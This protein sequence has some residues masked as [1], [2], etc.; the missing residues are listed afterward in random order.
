MAGGEMVPVDIYFVA[1][2]AVIVTLIGQIWGYYRRISKDS[3]KDMIDHALTSI[4]DDLNIIRT[5]LAVI[6][7]KVE[8]MWDGWNGN[9]S[10]NAAVLHHPEPSRSRVDYLLD[11]LRENTITPEELAELREHLE[12]I[13]HWEP[14]CEAPYAIFQGEQAAAANMLSALD[15]VYPETLDGLP[16]SPACCIEEAGTGL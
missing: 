12:T 10:R 15:V 5:D 7:T 11:C 16:D 8:P 4:K 6:R 2:V 1:A 13:M 3:V 14:G 9:L